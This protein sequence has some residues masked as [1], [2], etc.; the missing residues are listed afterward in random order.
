[1]GHYVAAHVYTPE[2]IRRAIDAGVKSIEHGHM[3]GRGEREADGGSGR[4][5]LQEGAWADM[6][7]VN[8]D[9]TKDINVL[10]DYGSD[11]A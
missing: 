9:P 11:P 10:Q 5:V 7:L 8:G 1:M 2:G 3:A 6:L 4:G